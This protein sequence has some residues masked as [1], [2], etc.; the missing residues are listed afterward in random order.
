MKAWS[1]LIFAALLSACGKAADLEAITQGFAERKDS[2]KRLYSMIQED[3]KIP[4]CFAVGL[5]HIGDY[6]AYKNKWS[7]SRNYERKITLE[8]VLKEVG[9]SNERYQEYLTLFKKTGSERIEYCS[10]KVEHRPD[11]PSWARI[12]VHRSGLAVSGCST[13]ININ[14]DGS[15][16]AT[17]VKPGYSRKIRPLGEGWYLNHDCT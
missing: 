12:L 9:I 1:I 5:D 10:E 8:L 7:S 14:G 3:T 11:M 2:F 6:W 17:E 4:S 13:T 15:I 16:P